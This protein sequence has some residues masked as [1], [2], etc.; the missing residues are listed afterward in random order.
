L[1]FALSLSIFLWYNFRV[2]SREIISFAKTI[3]RRGKQKMKALIALAH[4][5]ILFF[6]ASINSM[7]NLSALIWERVVFGVKKFTQLKA[8]FFTKFKKTTHNLRPASREKRQATPV[9][10]HINSEMIFVD[11]KYPTLGVVA[12]LL[13]AI[14]V[15][16]LPEKYQL[17]NLF[18]PQVS[19]DAAKNFVRVAGEE[20]YNPDNN[21]NLPP[22]TQAILE[23]HPNLYAIL[24]PTE[25]QG[26]NLKMGGMLLTRHNELFLATGT[27][28]SDSIRRHTI[29][30]INLATGAV[31]SRVIEN[32][33]VRS[34]DLAH[35]LALGKLNLEQLT[36]GFGVPSHFTMH[37]GDLFVSERLEVDSDAYF[38]KTIYVRD[39]SSIS[40]MTSD[41][42]QTTTANI[43]NILSNSNLHIRGR[44]PDEDTFHLYDFT[45]LFFYPS[46]ATVIGEA[47]LPVFSNID[48]VGDLYVKDDLEVG[49]VIYGTISGDFSPSGN[50]D[51]DSNIITNIGN[52]GTDFTASGGLN[53]ADN[54]GVTGTITATGGSSGNWNT[55]YGWGDHALQGYIKNISSFTTDNL[56]QGS[57]NLYS[58]WG[59]NGTGVYY[60][61]G[62]VGIGTTSPGEKVQ[63]SKSTIAEDEFVGI[64]INADNYGNNI[65][66]GMLGRSATA[67]G[68]IWLNQATPSVTNY[69]FLD[70]GGLWPTVFNAL[71][72]GMQ[73][74]IA[75]SPKM[76]IDSTGNVGIGTTSPGAKLDVVGNLL[77]QSS[78]ID[79]TAKEFDILVGHNTN[80]EEPFELLAGMSNSSQNVVYFGGGSASYNSATDIRFFTASTNTT[81]TG[82]ERIRITPAGGLSLGYTADPGSG[83]MIISGNVGIGTTSPDSALQVNGN[84]NLTL[85]KLFFNYNSAVD[86]SGISK[87]SSAGAVE[88][89]QA[90]NSANIQF[91]M[92]NGASNIYPLVLKSS[93]NVGIGTTAPVNALDVGTGGGIHITTGTPSATSM[94]LYNDSG[95]LTWNGTALSTGSGLS[96]GANNYIPIWTGASSQGISGIY[97][98]GG[99]VGIGTTS[100]NEKLTVNGNIS[101]FEAATSP[102][103]T[104]GYGK[105]YAKNDPYTK[106]LLHMDGSGTAFTDSSASRNAITAYL[107][108][109]QTNNSYKFSNGSSLFLDSTN[110]YV[111]VPDSEDW[112]FGSGDFTIDAWVKNTA[113]TTV[114]STMTSNS[115]PSPFVVSASTYNGPGYDAYY[116]FN[117]VK[118]AG[119]GWMSNNATSGWLKIDLGATNPKIITKYVVTGQNSSYLNRNPY[120]WT[121]EGSNDDSNWTT[122]DTRTSEASWTN[123]ESRTYSFS[124]SNSYRYYRM[125]ISASVS[126]PYLSV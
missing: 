112:N 93:G 62:N 87:L 25:A 33:A 114:V 107:G 121:F 11:T 105:L 123:Y 44:L 78:K 13:L 50:L 27:V 70:G 73:F 122:L 64:K 61:G 34:E 58:Q 117:G 15:Y 68:G 53:L 24:K 30:S 84:I 77:G 41:T 79:S 31:N 2:N 7:K 40:T 39:S 37:S 80:S 115:T 22:T 23:Q 52:T 56:T 67:L 92:W 1:H 32:G 71:S 9:T 48:G 100:P 120:S 108:A 72:G 126:D 8:K 20:T 75:N 85:G 6:S 88:I 74:R 14:F 18:T 49:G 26:E 29:K 12:V 94:A 95:T 109:N 5:L 99:N 47:S 59:T 102:N 38:D 106:L 45:E 104:S 69:S 110:D 103:A 91:K 116:A 19:E 125:N 66:L 51:I 101:L 3:A 55:A 113:N 17:T 42:L 54:L 60:T 28:V 10:K 46:G 36:I 89:S 83:S 63:I 16:A 90:T 111:S 81:T 65:K 97:Q 57:A 96:G 43:S 76:V 35:S 82:T 21:Q 98:I 86:P 118:T 4:S 124:N 119:Y